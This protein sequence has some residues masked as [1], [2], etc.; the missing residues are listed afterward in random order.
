MTHK[1][2]QAILDWL[3][4]TQTIELQADWLIFENNE[5]ATFNIIMPYYIGVE[6]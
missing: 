4:N 5:K 3:F 6:V 1:Q 2:H